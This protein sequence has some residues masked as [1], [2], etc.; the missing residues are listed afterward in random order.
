MPG[1]FERRLLKLSKGK[2]RIFCGD[3]NTKPAGVFYVERGEYTDL[4]AVDKNNVPERTERWADGRIRKGGWRRVLRILIQRKL[5]DR[6]AAERLFNT[7]LEYSTFDRVKMFNDPL[8]QKL[9][10]MK[11][12]SIEK[13]MSKTGQYI[14]NVLDVDELMTYREEK[15]RLKKQGEIL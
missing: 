14:P 13:M 3:D 5:V 4:C 10:A 11:Q 2:I 15:K 6:K 9:A 12:R 1:E 7:H 8:A